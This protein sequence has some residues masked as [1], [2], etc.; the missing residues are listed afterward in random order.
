MRGLGVCG[1]SQE[2]ASANKMFRNGA[3][4]PLCAQL[5]RSA[6]PWQAQEVYLIGRFSNES[7][8]SRI[9]TSSALPRSFAELSL[10]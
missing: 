4:N 9:V 7:D 1:I 6:E 2:N 5:G 3:P 8:V 10:L